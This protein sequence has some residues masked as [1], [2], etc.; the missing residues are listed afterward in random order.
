MQFQLPTLVTGSKMH[1]S[2]LPSLSCSTAPLPY[3]CFLWSPCKSNI[4]T[5]IFASGETQARYSLKNNISQRGHT[6][7]LNFMQVELTQEIYK[8]NATPGTQNIRIT[9]QPTAYTVISWSWKGFRWW[10][11]STSHLDLELL[12][13]KIPGQ[14]LFKYC[15]TQQT[16]QRN[17]TLHVEVP[18]LGWQW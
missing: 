6:L 8:E 15:K 17:S 13:L 14:R 7:T 5:P 16:I 2:R 11:S 9:Q 3:K 1:P 12:I 18:T 4:W 10:F